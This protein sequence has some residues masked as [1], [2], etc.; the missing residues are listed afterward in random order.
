MRYTIS[1]DRRGAPD[2]GP[3]PALRGRMSIDPE[4]LDATLAA[5][6]DFTRRNL[7][8]VKLRELDRN[9]EFPEELVRRMCS[10]ELGIQL[11]FVPE[12]YGGLGAGSFGIYRICEQLAGVDVG[13]ATGV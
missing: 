12:K 4:T 10:E 1:S 8:D 6:A 9:D 11:F 7:P 3:N 13:I 5:L 2:F